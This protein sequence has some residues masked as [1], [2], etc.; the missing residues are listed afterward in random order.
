MD[1]LRLPHTNIVGIKIFWCELFSLKK[2][3]TKVFD[4]NEFD[5]LTLQCLP[6]ELVRGKCPYTSLADS[7]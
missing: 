1:L 2:E 5:G 3:Q 6:N 7:A 4:I